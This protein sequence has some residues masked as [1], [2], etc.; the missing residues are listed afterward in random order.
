MKEVDGIVPN[1][2]LEMKA[3]QTDLHWVGDNYEVAYYGVD[4]KVFLDAD[5]ALFQYRY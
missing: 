5:P 1:S 2:W 4:P 3:V